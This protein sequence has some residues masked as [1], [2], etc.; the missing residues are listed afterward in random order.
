MQKK[1]HDLPKNSKD[2]PQF[3][4]RPKFQ[5]RLVIIHLTNIFMAISLYR[6]SV[7]IYLL[8]SN[9]DQSFFNLTCS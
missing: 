8:P 9:H 7:D 1:C 2:L 3:E 6:N 5:S 4:N